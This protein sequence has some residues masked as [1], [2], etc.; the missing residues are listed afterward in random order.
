[1]CPTFYFF[2]TKIV[3]V[4]NLALL[5]ILKL[6]FLLYGEFFVLFLC[7]AYTLQLEHS[8]EYVTFIHFQENILPGFF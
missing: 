1:M 8:I 4:V 2:E 7:Q 5:F 3:Y 6:M